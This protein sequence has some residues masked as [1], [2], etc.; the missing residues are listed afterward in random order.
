[1]KPLIRVEKNGDFYNFSIKY[2]SYIAT[3]SDDHDLPE[4]IGEYSYTIHHKSETQ[5]PPIHIGG[6]SGTI[7][8]IEL[9]GFVEYLLR[10]FDLHTFIDIEE[11]DEYEE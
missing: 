11:E 7:K 4:I 2:G 9:R 10:T 5:Y 1:M 8:V 6:S 3:I